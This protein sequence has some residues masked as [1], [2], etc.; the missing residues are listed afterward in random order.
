MEGATMFAMVLFVTAGSVG[1][2]AAMFVALATG[3]A[4]GALRR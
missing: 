3:H 1:Y 2:A 4:V